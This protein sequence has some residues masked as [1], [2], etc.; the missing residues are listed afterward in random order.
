MP[1][2]CYIFQ[3]WAQG[4]TKLKDC[5]LLDASGVRTLNTAFRLP[6]PPAG[7]MELRSDGHFYVKSDHPSGSAVLR[8]VAVPVIRTNGAWTVCSWL[9]DTGPMKNWHSMLL[10]NGMTLAYGRGYLSVRQVRA[11]R[12]RTMPR[13]TD[14]VH[15]PC[16]RKEG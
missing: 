8:D 1:K 6:C 14:L 5:P 3:S 11:A 9:M 7:D 16:V 2:Y 4:D 15:A 12:V 10:A 13:K